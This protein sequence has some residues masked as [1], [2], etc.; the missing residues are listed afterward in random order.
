MSDTLSRQ[1][2]RNRQFWEQHVQQWQESGLSK[3]AYCQRHNLSSG[4]FYNWSR[5]TNGKKKTKMDKSTQE[6]GSALQLVPVS[7]ESDLSLSSSVLV[8]RASTRIHLP[9][10]LSDHQISTWLQAVHRLHV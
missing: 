8:E 7:V 1:P 6:T 10:E 4:S 5:P 3:I 2:P 9:V